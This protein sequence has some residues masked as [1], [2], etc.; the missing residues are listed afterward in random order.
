MVSP[1]GCGIMRSERSQ[2]PFAG[3]SAMPDY[4]FQSVIALF[5]A[6]VASVL[7]VS[8]ATAQTTR[9]WLPGDGNW[10]ELTHWS[11]EGVPGAGDD[12]RIQPVNLSGFT[13]S[14]TYDYEGAP[15][16]LDS[17]IVELLLTDSA[18][19]TLEL[20]ANNLTAG[21][22]YIGKDGTGTVN[23]TGGTNTVNGE[24]HMYIGY[25]SGSI[26]TYK[27]SGTGSLTATASELAGVDG[28]GTIAQ[29]GGT[30]TTKGLELGV[31]TGTGTYNLSAG[32]LSSNAAEYV[33]N[34]GTGIFN[35]DGGTN[36]VGGAN[37]MYIGYSA[38]SRGQ[39]NLSGTGSLSASGF[40]FVGIDGMG[41]ISQ[42]GGT[43]STSG[44]VLGVRS[45]TGVYNL[46]AGSLS[47]SISESVGGSG[48]GTFNQ[49][50]GTNTVAANNNMYIGN[51]AGSFGVYNL[52]EAGSLSVGS[53]EQVGGLGTGTFNQT[54]GTNSTNTLDVLGLSGPTATYNLNAGSLS[55]QSEEIGRRNNSDIYAGTFH[56]TGGTNTISGTGLSIGA[57]G[58]TGIYLLEGGTTTVAGGTL[59]VGFNLT[60]APNDGVGILTVSGTG[61]LNASSL[62]IASTPAT[63]V[64]LNG[65]TIN[66]GS[67]ISRGKFTINS[68]TLIVGDVTIISG[69]LSI[70]LG[71]TNRES[72]YGALTASGNVK[73]AD[74][75]AVVFDDFSPLAGESFDI[76]DWGSL[77]G[78]FSSISLPALSDGL[79][80]DQSQLY[81]TGVL[82][83]VLAG[84]YNKNGI[85]DA[86]DYTVWRDS[87]GSTTSLA[88]DG[89]DNGV[90]D[91]GD[92]DVWVSK[93][94]NRSGSGANATAAV[95]E[96][97]TLRMF[98]VGILT[99][100]VHRRCA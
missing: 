18:T 68:G 65:G 17:L 28:K 69:T 89:N 53:V 98:L 5:T 96:P 40:E 16:T 1:I 84:D 54:G 72:D 64:T 23:Q 97:A 56:Q 83:V 45:G 59:S 95:P 31:S 81:V 48:T 44:L 50:G 32:S 35:H 30:N 77:S 3:T 60:I 9:Y 24:N 29:S 74:S 26:G 43:N 34:A 79:A 49:S 93:F 80:W 19:T 92:Y 8:L 47:S 46:N 71:G 76:L 15:V 42:S 57:T 33:G 51:A 20:P 27:L 78:T 2:I 91:A 55:A 14:V 94:G 88:A 85:V 52:S 62:S 73:L 10:S 13:Q 38:G 75:L 11:P 7:S 36:T 66:V 58:G 90:I 82:S 6:L 21:H 4:R 61:T 25:A 41:T 22:E 87:L 100:C 63:S 99:L 37:H 86:A 39:Y 12:V 70:G 67:I